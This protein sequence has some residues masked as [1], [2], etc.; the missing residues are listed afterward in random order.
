MDADRAPAAAPP[1][2]SRIRRAD[3]GDQVLLASEPLGLWRGSFGLAVFGPLVMLVPL[4]ILWRLRA[5]GQPTDPLVHVWLTCLFVI[6]AAI[7]LVGA[8]FGLGRIEIRVGAH[9]LSLR[10]R[11][12]LRRWMREVGRDQLRD[13]RLDEAWFQAGRAPVHQLAIELADG[14]TVR[15]L[16]AHARPD[17]CYVAD[18]IRA[19]MNLRS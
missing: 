2:G 19:K 7:A 9:V 15:I 14:R 8:D 13:V 1:P 11:G 17:I 16:T 3:T 4:V 5:A 6:G 18:C 10:R 12:L